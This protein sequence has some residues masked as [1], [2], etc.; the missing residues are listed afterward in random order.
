[1]L[2]VCWV[3]LGLLSR[4]SKSQ[5]K[6]RS[7]RPRKAPE[8]FRPEFYKN[9]K[10]G[11][12]FFEDFWRSLRPFG[13]VSPRRLAEYNFYRQ[14]SS[15][16]GRKLTLKI[17]IFGPNLAEIPNPPFLEG[18]VSGVF[19]LL[20][21]NVGGTGSPLPPRLRPAQTRWNLRRRTLRIPPPKKPSCDSVTKMANKWPKTKIRRLSR[22][23]SPVSLN[24]FA[25][26]LVR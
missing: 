13:S 3:E 12:I 18:D 11:E 14:P 23:R 19:W 22:P 26:T 17:A 6:R 4:P 25:K 24:R 7:G 2:G 1:M 8:K 16:S 15:R 9:P 10:C 21:A 5:L 20:R